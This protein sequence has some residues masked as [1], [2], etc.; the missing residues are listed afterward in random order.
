M[1]LSI[2]RK[3]TSLMSM[4]RCC[5]M[6]VSLLLVSG[7]GGQAFAADKP[8]DQIYLPTPSESKVDMVTQGIQAKSPQLFRGYA[9]VGTKLRFYEHADVGVSFHNVPVCNR[10]DMSCNELPGTHHTRP[11]GTLECMPNGQWQKKD[12]EGSCFLPPFGCCYRNNNAQIVVDHGCRVIHPGRNMDV[13]LDGMFRNTVNVDD[14]NC[15]DDVNLSN[16]VEKELCIFNYEGQP[17]ISGDTGDDMLRLR[18]GG[19]AYFVF[20]IAD[21]R[22]RYIWRDPFVDANNDGL[23]DTYGERPDPIMIPTGPAGSHTD[24][25]NFLDN[26][27]PFVHVE[28]ACPPVGVKLCTSLAG[29]MPPPPAV[30]AV[31][32]EAHG[33]TGYK[34]LD[35]IPEEELCNFGDFLGLDASAHELHWMC[36]PPAEFSEGG[37]NNAECSAGRAYDGECG[38][39]A[40]QADEYSD[41]AEIDEANFCVHAAVATNKSQSA[42]QITWQC[43]GLNG[44]E[45]V[46]CSVS[47]N[48]V[49]GEGQQVLPDRSGC[50]DVYIVYSRQQEGDSGDMAEPTCGSNVDGLLRCGSGLPETETR[51]RNCSK[52]GTFEVVGTCLSGWDCPTDSYPGNM[53]TTPCN[54]WSGDADSPAETRCVPEG[55]L[56]STLC[57]P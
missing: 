30:D 38:V 9:R 14:Y 48:I 55:E 33:E 52:S 4:V 50:G 44:G 25:L 21:I 45:P 36:T 11:E 57:M 6:V 16:P 10:P 12:L 19:G 31:C 37:G 29:V 42:S 24:F 32:G 28:F 46:Q 34:S 8:G 27:P 41:Y 2:S 35:D 5:V 22:P 15:N 51:M 3:G 43:D 23:G 54:G 1:N 47:R 56:S 17:G 13:T 39:A 40:S 7:I 53:P 20:R 49:C 18:A 26:P